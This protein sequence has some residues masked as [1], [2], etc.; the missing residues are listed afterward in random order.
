MTWISSLYDSCYSIYP[1]DSLAEDVLLVTASNPNNLTI[2]VHLVTNLL[3]SFGG[4]TGDPQ[5]QIWIL[6]CL[7][8]LTEAHAV[9]CFLFQNKVQSELTPLAVAWR[10]LWNVLFQP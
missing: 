8:H 4:P 3:G 10:Y 2:L 9:I 6:L 5:L 1:K 7:I